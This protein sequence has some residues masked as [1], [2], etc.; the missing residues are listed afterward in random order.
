M[1]LSGRFA[2]LRD[3]ARRGFRGYPL[4][5]VAYYGPDASRA[6]RSQWASS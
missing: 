1:V 2:A 3:K 4:A 5:T 6:Q